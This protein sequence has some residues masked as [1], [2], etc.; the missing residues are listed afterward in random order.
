MYISVFRLPVLLNHNGKVSKIGYSSQ[1]RKVKSGRSW[2]QGIFVDE[3][4]Y[5]NED[6]VIDLDWLAALLSEVYMVKIVLTGYFC[7][8]KRIVKH[9]V[10]H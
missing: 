6:S 2:H 8:C 7:N 10:K 3:M 1:T 9:T 4:G 5:E